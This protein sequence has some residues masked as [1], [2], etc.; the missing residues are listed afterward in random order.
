VLIKYK[1][2]FTLSWMPLLSVCNSLN[3]QQT[4]LCFCTT[5]GEFYELSEYRLGGNKQWY[6]NDTECLSVCLSEHSHCMALSLGPVTTFPDVRY[7]VDGYSCS[8]FFTRGS[9]Y[10]SHSV[11]EVTSH[12]CAVHHRVPQKPGKYLSY[13][14]SCSLNSSPNIISV[15]KSRM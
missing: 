1:G 11:S 3:P 5:I 4:F 10:T 7:V 12:H 13:L 2:S 6:S 15:I 14:I 9:A 8:E